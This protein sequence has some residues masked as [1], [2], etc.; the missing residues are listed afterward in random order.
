MIVL[1]TEIQ[2]K[3]LTDNLLGQRVMVYY[4]LHKHTFSVQKAGLVILHADYLKL[5]DVEF[6]VRKGGLEKVRKQK[7]KNVHAF[8][9]GIIEDFC[10]YPC[11]ELPLPPNDNIITYNPYKHESFVIKQT[12]DPIHTANEVEMINDKNKIFLLN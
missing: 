5:S 1:I 10:M 8:V 12:D 4:N 6:R 3:V 7:T 2:K 9:I 11:Q